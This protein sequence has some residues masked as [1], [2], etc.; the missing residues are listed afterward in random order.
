M[1]TFMKPVGD[2]EAVLLGQGE[3]GGEEG[4]CGGAHDKENN[5]FLVKRK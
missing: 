3:Q 4:F 1:K 2:H 5:G